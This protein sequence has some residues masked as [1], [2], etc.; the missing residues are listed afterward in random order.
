VVIKIPPEGPA[1]TAAAF[2]PFKLQLQGR[3]SRSTASTRS[4]DLRRQGSHLCTERY[5][6]IR[7]VAQRGNRGGKD[8]L[9]Q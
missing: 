9:R 2:Q 4:L 8:I 3:D 6:V 7:P 1:P 5:E